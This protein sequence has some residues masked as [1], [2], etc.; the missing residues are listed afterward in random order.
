M[1]RNIVHSITH[2]LLNHHL[3]HCTRSTSGNILLTWGK[4]SYKHL[5]SYQTDKFNYIPPTCPPLPYDSGEGY[6]IHPSNGCTHQH[7]QVRQNRVQPLCM[8]E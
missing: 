8:T 5:W 3:H 2:E 1:N 4:K 6:G 7:F